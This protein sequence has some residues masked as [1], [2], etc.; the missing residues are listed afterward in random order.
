[1]NELVFVRAKTYI[2]YKQIKTFSQN[3]QHKIEK[4]SQWNREFFH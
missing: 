3:E 1:M 2:V 4:E